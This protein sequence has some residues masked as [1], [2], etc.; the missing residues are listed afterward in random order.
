MPEFEICQHLYEDLVLCSLL[1]NEKTSHKIGLCNIK[2]DSK[3][4]HFSRHFFYKNIVF[5]LTLSIVFSKVMLLSFSHEIE[6]M[7]WRHK[8][9]NPRIE[10]N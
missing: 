10:G 7:V 1:L 3:I 4:S 6:N 2:K 5:K 8:D 9:K